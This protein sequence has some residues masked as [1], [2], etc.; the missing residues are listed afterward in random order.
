MGNVLQAGQPHLR[1]SCSAQASNHGCCDLH[2]VCGSG[3]RTVMD[4]A[5]GIKAEEWTTVVAGGMENMSLSPHLME[6]L[7]AATEWAM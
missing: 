1:A 3:L 5:N 4:A 7:E 2:K 6:R